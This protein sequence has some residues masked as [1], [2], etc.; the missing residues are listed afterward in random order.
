MIHFATLFI[1]A[2][3]FAMGCAKSPSAAEE[4]P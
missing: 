2:S 3:L 1:L 4:K